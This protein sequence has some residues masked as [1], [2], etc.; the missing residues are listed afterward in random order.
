MRLYSTYA[1]GW[2]FV[3]AFNA[4]RLYY[5][6]VVVKLAKIILTYMVE[7]SRH[8]IF[9]VFHRENMCIEKHSNVYLHKEGCRQVCSLFFPRVCT[10]HGV[11]LDLSELRMAKICLGIVR[12]LLGRCTLQIP[13]PIPGGGGE[14]EGGAKPLQGTASAF[15][16]RSNGWMIWLEQGSLDMPA[17]IEV[18]MSLH[19]A[20]FLAFQST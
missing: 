10:V 18:D 12:Q 3:I 7:C 16:F 13:Q 6:L 4:I 14:G 19:A 8:P 5:F 11:E 15:V 9:T 1:R 2:I 17:D 20:W